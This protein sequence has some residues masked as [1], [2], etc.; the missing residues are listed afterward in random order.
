M[1]HNIILDQ[2]ENISV[3]GTDHVLIGS[4][5]DG[6]TQMTKVKNT[7]SY[8]LTKTYRVPQGNVLGSTL[9]LKRINDLLQEDVYCYAMVTV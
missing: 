6:R 3:R 1:D 7:V 8:T 4:Y 2:L 9:F 5:L